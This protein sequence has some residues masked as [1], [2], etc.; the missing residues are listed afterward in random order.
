METKQKK[1]LSEAF[2][3]L[4]NPAPLSVDLEFDPESA[5]KVEEKE[6]SYEDDDDEKNVS[7]SLRKRKFDFLEDGD[8]RYDGTKVSRKSLGMDESD[9]NIDQW[10]EAD[11]ISSDVNDEKSEE[12]SD[13]NHSNGDENDSDSSAEDEINSEDNED[14]F[15]H[16]SSKS[17]DLEVERGI[18][19]RNQ[20]NL[21][22]SLLEC[23]IT[24][25]KT[26]IASNKLPQHGIFEQFLS[27]GGSNYKSEIQQTKNNIANLLEKFIALQT[28]MLKS[29]PETK[30]LDKF[31][32]KVSTETDEIN[33]DTEGEEEY[34]SNHEDE[35]EEQKKE[36]HK[37]S[38]RS[39][40]EYAKF[41]GE[42]H[43]KYKIYRNATIQKWNDKTR[44]SVGK[45]SSR[46][47]SSFEQSTLKQIEQVLSNRQR[48][49]Q[50]TQLKRSSYNILGQELIRESDKQ[51]EESNPSADTNDLKDS[52][53][54]NKEYNSEIFDDTDFY[55]QL[56]R[57]L[58]E[59]KSSD[60]TDP[61]QLGRQWLKLQKLRSKMK[62][63]IDTRATKGRKI[64]Y[65]VHPKLVNFMAPEDKSV[66][67][68]EAKTELFSSLFGNNK[69]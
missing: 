67:T 8:E 48:L 26:L 27:E 44:I 45:L 59:K 35:G 23:R 30:N 37:T 13:D 1:S 3:D 4:I 43:E 51:I 61:I 28:I 33:S 6:D 46:N 14:N 5:A 40:K 42:Q 29:Y 9:S 20:L 36:K 57:D 66:W 15:Q 16:I 22:D 31:Q 39:I 52:H 32:N 53:E 38:K 17:S 56:L 47:F 50:R 10:E 63:K 58:I 25:Q 64:R 49:I 54:Q 18:A 12:D 7:S 69:R 62:R 68:E 34:L 60:V 65:V 11:V 19:V 55:H 41:L 21:W 2:M 24:L